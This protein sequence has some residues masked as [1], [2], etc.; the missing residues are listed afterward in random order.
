MNRGTAM[1][2][3]GMSR[4]N[5]GTSDGGDMSDMDRMSNRD[6]DMDNSTMGT[7]SWC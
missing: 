7:D 2:N 3:T 1:V 4:T 6:N 5:T